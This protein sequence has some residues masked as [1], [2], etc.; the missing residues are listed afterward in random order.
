LLNARLPKKMDGLTWLSFE[1]RLIG[2]YPGSS[3][4]ASQGNKLI[5]VADMNVMVVERI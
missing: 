2:F 3:T 4:C 1:T 5:P